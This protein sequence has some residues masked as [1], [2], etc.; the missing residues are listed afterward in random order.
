LKA[1]KPEKKPFGRD[2]PPK[3]Y[4][5]DQSV[6]ADPNNWRYPLHTPWN[7]KAARRYFDEPSNRAK[8]TE[9]EQAYIDWRIDEA[10][11]RFAQTSGFRG[12]KRPS[13]KPPARKKIEQLSLNEL[14][15]VFLGT[16]RLERAVE[17]EDSLV[18]ISNMT[19]ERID[20]RVKE[21][22]VYIDLKNHTISHDCQ[23]W[24][25]NMDSKNMCKHLGKLL[26]SLE[27]NRAMD[28]L[29]DILKHKDEWKFTAP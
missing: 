11:K 9:E 19:P 7:A 2:S 15:R 14:L 20:A 6:Y 13:P 23:D 24:R 26:L 21:Y 22:V 4:P 18:S 3:G 29:R 16:A 8:Y 1:K 12:V 25:K 10:L 28:L 27:P 17:I 5:R